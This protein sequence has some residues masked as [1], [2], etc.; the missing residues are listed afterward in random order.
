MIHLSAYTYNIIRRVF[1][2]LR[3]YALRP[4]FKSHGCRFWFDPDGYYTY[5]NIFVGDNVNLG[6]KPILIAELS[7][8]HIGNHVM[9]GP[10]VVVIGGGHNIKVI[11]CF[12]TDVYEKTGNED[13]G[14]IIEDEVWIGSRAMILR[15]VTIGRGAVIGAAA[16]VNKSV[17]PYA[18]V[19]GN[20][21]K[22]LRFRFGVDD[23]LK[24]EEILYP[25]NARLKREDLERWQREWKMLS[26]LRKVFL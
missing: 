17:P 13:L 12:M 15:G 14:V 9:F 20:P 24:H 2:R 6:I 26:P 3:M 4:L 18:I 1:R 16:L 19:G 8:I 25:A 10:E 5:R 22:V 7:E 23:I 11:G 21:A